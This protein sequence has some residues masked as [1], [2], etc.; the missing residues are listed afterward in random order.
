[1][2][3][4]EK[5]A[6][7]GIHRVKMKQKE[8]YHKNYARPCDVLVIGSGGAGLRAAIVAREQGT[9]VLLL[10]KSPL[11]YASCTMCAGG[12]FTFSVP[13]GLDVEGH[14]RNTLET[15]RGLNDERLVRI[16]CQG[17][18]EA[19]RELERFGVPMHYEDDGGRSGSFDPPLRR[20]TSIVRCMTAH[21]RKIGVRAQ[22][23][24]AVAALVQDGHGAVAGALGLV[25]GTGELVCYPAKAVVLATGGAGA[26]YP[27]NDN[28]RQ[29]SGDGYALAYR[30]GA[31][32]MDM[33]FVQFLPS[34]LAEPGLPPYGISFWWMDFCPI[35]N[36]RGEEFLRALINEH[37]FRTGREAGPYLR[38]LASRAVALEV[39]EG[40]G[41]EGAVFM[42][43]SEV[44]SEQQGQD[45]QLRVFV[46]KVLPR[47][48]YRERPL[49]VAPLA[50][51]FM[52]GVVVSEHGETSLPGLF[53]AGEVCAGVH[54]ANRHRGNALTDIIVFGRR[55]GEAAAE[56]ARKG[57]GATPQ[58]AE[59]A[60]AGDE[61]RRWL[62]DPGRGDLTARELR[63]AV[64]AV[65]ME[66]LYVIR[67]ADGLQRALTRL[68]EMEEQGVYVAR[69]KELVGLL[70][71][72]NLLLVAKL[73]A[74][75]ALQRRESRGAHFRL[76]YPQRD[77]M[78]WR[79]HIVLEKPPA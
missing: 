6:K 67:S 64:R 35:T 52:G 74:Q 58:A 77:D 17:G 10:A 15:G 13:G 45:P 75:A 39:C 5:L 70:E 30:A 62:G 25:A 31:H 28:P 36:N 73:V 29:I 56:W 26:L 48:P 38:D 49:H 3:L 32:L 79:R 55:A 40:R 60:S 61:L 68:A 42:D 41:H 76:D 54:G 9:E 19:V 37:G 4:P 16:F 78:H 21:A 69:M 18:P 51:Y 66:H 46:E 23:G 11:G 44:T 71:A 47:L 65:A 20:G 8:N 27:R 72:R 63:E 12:L 1:M 14:Y 7:V 57:N 22:E 2:P 34:G 53:A 50:H 59:V 24:V 33:E 43:F